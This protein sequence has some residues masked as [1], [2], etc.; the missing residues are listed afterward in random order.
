MDVRYVCTHVYV[1]MSTQCV[2]SMRGSTACKK[3]GQNSEVGSEA[4]P[5]RS[6]RVLNTMKN[7]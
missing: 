1:V 7:T 6:Y 5:S 4:Q 3:E 2:S